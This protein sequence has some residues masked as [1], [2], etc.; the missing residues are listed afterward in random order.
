MF[1]GH[2]LCRRLLEQ[3]RNLW[4]GHILWR[5][6][7]RL[8]ILWGGHILW[9]RRGRVYVL[10]GEL[11]SVV[12][13]MYCFDQLHLQR[14]LYG[15]QRRCLFGLRHWNL[16]NHNWHCDVHGV[17]YSFQLARFKHNPH[18]LHMQRGLHGPERWSVH[19]LRHRNLQNHHRRCDVHSMSSR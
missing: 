5:R 7:G 18:C 10:S 6:L 11:G 4:G 15:T 2:I 8:R 12:Q 16:Q 14:R 13:W 17:S 19:Q 1:A 9:H 3:L